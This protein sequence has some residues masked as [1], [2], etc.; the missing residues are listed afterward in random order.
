MLL[1]NILIDDRMKMTNAF[2]KSLISA[3]GHL[4]SDD[5]KYILDN[6]EKFI[7]NRTVI[8]FPYVN[9]HIPAFLVSLENKLRI[10]NYTINKYDISVDEPATGPNDII[11]ANDMSRLYCLLWRENKDYE[12]INTLCTFKYEHPSDL[13]LAFVQLSNHI[14]K[15]ELNPF[16]YPDAMTALAIYYDIIMTLKINSIGICEAYMMETQTKAFSYMCSMLKNGDIDMISSYEYEIL[17][18]EI[19]ILTSLVSI[20]DVKKNLDCLKTPVMLSEMTGDTKSSLINE[21]ISLIEKRSDTDPFVTNKFETCR[22]PRIKSFSFTLDKNVRKINNS[23][24]YLVENTTRERIK[25]MIEDKTGVLEDLD[26]ISFD[27]PED[28]LIM[29]ELEFSREYPIVLTYIPTDSTIT[30][31]GSDWRHIIY[32]ED[33]VLVAFYLKDSPKKL[34]AIHIYCHIDEDMN[35]TLVE[36]TGKQNGR[37]EFVY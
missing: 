13:F 18:L 1:N 32:Y 3:F 23:L 22:I 21:V 17:L 15:R 27:I 12:I 20:S 36:F 5:Q 4:K 7:P 28:L 25:D 16:I 31:D 11:V 37:Y 10:L 35:C 33:E 34:Y 14:T 30:R 2:K 6:I 29:Y 9:D 26:N 24:E 19:N 8:Y